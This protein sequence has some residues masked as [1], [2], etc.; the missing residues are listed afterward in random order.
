MDFDSLRSTFLR[1]LP[2]FII[3]MILLGMV[4]FGVRTVLPR[5]QNYQDISTQVS[6]QSD[7][8]A[9]QLAAQ[10]DSTTQLILQHQIDLM[11]ADLSQNAA[12]FLS[13]P[14]AEQVLN[15]LYNYAYSRGVRVSNL[16]AQPSSVDAANTG[17]YEALLYQVQ[18]DGGTSNLIDFLAH[19]KEASLPAVQIVSMSAVPNGSTTTLRMNVQFYTS[20]F[21][22]GQALAGFPTPEPIIPSDTP[23][24]TFTPTETPT[25]TAI[26]PTIVPPTAT[27]T[28]SPLPPSPTP[29]HSLTPLPAPTD[30]L[31]ATAVTNIVASTEEVVLCPGAPPTLFRQGDLAVVH[32]VGLGALRVLSDPN[33]PATSTRTQAYDNQVLDIIAGPVCANQMYYWYIRNTSAGNALGWV[34]EGQGTERWLCPQ[35]DPECAALG[36]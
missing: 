2:G 3:F 17:V 14:E 23:T 13:R 33:A 24:A 32:F 28:P 35:A 22:S 12:V 8:V 36:G 21:A 18:V 26:P 15:R 11:Q 1:M 34:S 30:V 16:Q 6:F 19:F 5:W 7:A 20:P 4:L 25:E 27:F 31:P 29:T 9:T 10:N